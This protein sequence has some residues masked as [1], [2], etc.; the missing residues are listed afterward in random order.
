MKKELGLEVGIINV[1]LNL[2][3]GKLMPESIQWD[4][5]RLIFNSLKNFVL[6]ALELEFG[7]T[8]SEKIFNMV[9]WISKQL[10]C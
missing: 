7:Q 6:R 3:F 9:V 2:D 10:I 8:L 5:A 4:L 1:A